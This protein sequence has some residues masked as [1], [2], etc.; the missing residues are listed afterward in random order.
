MSTLD[1]I[2]AHSEATAQFE[3]MDFSESTELVGE[4]L[5]ACPGEPANA[6]NIVAFM[7]AKKVLV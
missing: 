2:R 5:K 7:V 4:F 1:F 3:S 6:I